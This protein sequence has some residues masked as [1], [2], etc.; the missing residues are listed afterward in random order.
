MSEITLEH[1]NNQMNLILN[2]LQDL[3]SRVQKLEVRMDSMEDVMKSIQKLLFD[4]IEA[5]GHMEMEFRRKFKEIDER[6]DQIDERFS[7][8][9]EKLEYVEYS[10]SDHS[11]KFDIVIKKVNETHEIIRN[12][13]LRLQK[14]ENQHGS[15]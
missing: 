12:H 7:H 13:E 8:I 2:I 4:H 5:T 1:L 10:T 3:S 14:L 11:L 6:F 15:P 9:D